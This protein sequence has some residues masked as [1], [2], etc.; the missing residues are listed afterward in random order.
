MA[1]VLAAVTR[2]GRKV[3]VDEEEEEEHPC[4]KIENLITFFSQIE[5]QHVFQENPWIIQYKNTFSNTGR[6]LYATQPN[7]LRTVTTPFTSPEANIKVGV[8]EFTWFPGELQ[9][10][11]G[12]LGES[13]HQL[14][15]KHI[16]KP[17]TAWANVGRKNPEFAWK[18]S[19]IQ[20][21]RKFG[22]WLHVSLA[23]RDGPISQKIPTYPGTTQTPCGSQNSFI[24]W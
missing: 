22:S 9:G 2:R 13:I 1:A 16:E 18:I 10:G 6:I 4:L 21:L 15:G 7:G 23:G 8:S 11:R 5:K 12:K 19:W 20:Y 3:D 17:S 24:N 14:S